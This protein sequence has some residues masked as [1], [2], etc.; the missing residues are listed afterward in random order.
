MKSVVYDHIDRD[1][2]V[3]RVSELRSISRV[4]T[5]R[6]GHSE[7]VRGPKRVFRAVEH[8]LASRKSLFVLY[9]QP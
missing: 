2:S 3:A 7:R 6:S 4:L 5:V 8:G 9:F 1:V